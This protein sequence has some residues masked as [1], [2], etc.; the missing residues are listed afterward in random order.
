MKSNWKRAI[1]CFLALA[2]IAVLGAGCGDDGDG[3]EV[4]IVIGEV[5]DLTGSASTACVPVHYA[6]EDV[7]KYFNEQGFI[8]G[9]ELKLV[10]YDTSYQ[11]AKD[12]PGYEWCKER[13][14]E[15]IITS[16]PTTGEVLKAFADKDKVVQLALG[17]TEP[18]IEPPGW[19]LCC[20]APM[21][22]QVT[23][24]LKWISEEHWN[25]E[26]E[27]RLPKMGLVQWAAAVG[28]AFEKGFT[29]YINAHQDEFEFV[30]VILAPPGT[31]GY[32]PEADAVKDCDYIVAPTLVGGA[33][34][35]DYLAR[36]Y[37]GATFCAGM[38]AGSFR[39]FFVKMVGWEKLDGFLTMEMC[40][41]QGEEQYPMVALPYDLLRKYHTAS[42][43]EELISA[44][45]GYT[46]A[47]TTIYP[48][49]QILQEAIAEVGAEN[50]NGQAYYD[51]ALDF[52][53]QYEGFPKWYYT[54]TVRYL[55]HDLAVYEWSAATE[56]VVRKSDWLPLVPVPD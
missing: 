47:F 4:T 52:E 31:M 14:A 38:S 19:T 39:G 56:G 36:G 37:S 1:A 21:E 28:I 23:T 50:F 7:L 34:I 15:V 18:M 30:D 11:P 2:L 32:G 42:E 55:V 53:V 45:T 16:L 51:A 9:V 20:A 35:R 5:T 29:K 46:A 13:G 12:V 25:Y 40:R 33:L 10:T 8:P 41:Q 27:G 49:F 3:G 44:G 24:L 43:A 6:T 48:L 22:E 26:A 17:N 54:E